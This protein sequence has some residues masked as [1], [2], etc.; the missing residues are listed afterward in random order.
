MLKK[1][2]KNR[3]ISKTA[4]T[5]SIVF[6]VCFLFFFALVLNSTHPITI[7]EV[8]T[9][10]QPENKINN[11]IDKSIAYY[12][13]IYNYVDPR[14]ISSLSSPLYDNKFPLIAAD[15]EKANAVKEAFLHAYNSYKTFCW[16]HDELQPITKKCKDTL[17]AGLTI[18]DSITTLY[19]MNLTKEYREARDFIANDFKPNG[20]WSL[21][22][23]IIRFVGGFISIYQLSNDKIFL[24]KAIQCTDAILPLFNSDGFYSSGFNLN[25]DE[26]GKITATSTTR[27]KSFNLAEIGT[28]QIE[29]LTLTALTGDTKYMDL[30]LKVYKKLW[31]D[32]P[33]RSIL[34][35]ATENQLDER[36]NR[37]NK[38]LPRHLGAGTD[39]YFEYIIKS[40]I[41]TN[42]VSPR[43][44][45]QHM[46]IVQEMRDTLLF[47]TKNL[48]LI[49]MG[50]LK[51][52]DL[53]PMIEHLATFVPGMVAIGTVKNN[54]KKVE[55]LKLAGEIV[56][57][58]S[59]VMNNTV[60]KLMPEKV[61]FNLYEENMKKEFQIISN[62]YLLRPE[63]VESIFYMFRFTGEQKYRDIAWNFFV[64]INESCRVKNGFV[65][66]NGLDKQVSPIDI[67]DSWFLAETLNYLYLTFTDTRLISPAEWVFNTESHPLHVWPQD[68]SKK[69]K[70]Y[71][72]LEGV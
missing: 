19:I 29:F 16:K 62:E 67:M 10:E 12:N 63:S 34:K 13:D 69:Y 26:N 51:H 5:A 27:T 33:K 60:A 40:Y 43:I 25:T 4:V 2:K 50:V 56:D 20:R 71:L 23:F 44:L 72:L 11:K 1:Q 68:V 66:V 6:I 59:Y 39:S 55:D 24:D 32:N 64:G 47:E 70:K 3:G 57:T 48:H 52:D 41:L 22:E 15:P 18:V 49:G 17:N 14:L 65:S 9:R 28:Y 38:D 35:S 61:S 42:G 31:K 30:A 53:Q 8:I 21:F 58:I 37:R 54:N 46:K 36:K 7:S 45:K